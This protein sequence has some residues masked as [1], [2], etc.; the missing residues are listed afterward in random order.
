M[1]RLLIAPAERADI[2]FDFSQHAGEKIVLKSAS[3]DIMQFRV[4]SSGAS[5]NSSLPPALKTVPR[6]PESQAIKTR[7]LTLDETMDKVQQSMGMMLNN[8]PW[9]MPVTEKPVINTTET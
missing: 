9:H 7:R 5:D 8:T 4:A 2:I 3:F 1:K 6:I